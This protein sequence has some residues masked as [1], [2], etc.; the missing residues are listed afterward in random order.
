MLKTLS[1]F[2]GKKALVVGLARSGVGS[3]NLLHHLGC[4]VTVTDIKP[5]HELKSFA[6]KLH[7]DI[8]QVLGSH[9][10]ELFKS[11]HLIVISPGVP[12]TMS[13]LSE[14]I[15][16]GKEVFGEFELSYRVLRSLCDAKFYA[17]TGSNGKSTT[18]SL[19]YEIF[20]HA[21]KSVIIGGNIGNALSEE[22]M[23]LRLLG[24][25]TDL[26]PEFVVVE[27]SSFQLETVRDFKPKAC[28]ILNISTDHLD[29]YHD[30]KPYIDA[31]CNIFKNQTQDDILVLNADDTATEYISSKATAVSKLFFSRTSKTN[32][33]WFENGLIFADGGKFTLNVKDMTLK[34][35]HNIENTMAAIIMAVHAGCSEDAIKEAVCN[36]KGLPHRVEFVRE[37]R[38]VKFIND[39]KGTNT[40]AVIK[41]LEGFDSPVILIAGGRDKDSNFSEL[42]P[43]VQRCVKSV[44]LIGEAST[45]IA[46]SLNG[47]AKCIFASSLKDAVSKAF[48]QATA[49]DT[50][51]LS[52][53]CASFDMFRDFEDRGNQFKEIVMSLC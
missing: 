4:K 8:K 22:I 43:Q 1:E 6:L 16:E 27:L 20:R 13:P 35:L 3:A 52:P 2:R 36:F 17:V 33:A 32:G 15:K 14:A 9:P 28:T 11:A 48:E 10:F 31:K 24:G 42:I 21:N 5:P 12:L 34:G 38:G 23:K 18:T 49:G 46:Q 50:V 30:M 29:R 45:K 47:T 40:G 37:L 51:L 41:S 39:S 26:V 53:A 7:P 19:L 44:V 25:S